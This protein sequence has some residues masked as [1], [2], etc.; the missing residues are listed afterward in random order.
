MKWCFLIRFLL[1]FREGNSIS[2]HKVKRYLIVLDILVDFKPRNHLHSSCYQTG[3]WAGLI[4]T[5]LSRKN[6]SWARVCPA[7]VNKVSPRSCFVSSYRLDSSDHNPRMTVPTSR[8]CCAHYHQRQ[9]HFNFNAH[10][11]LPNAAFEVNEEEAGLTD[12]K[13]SDD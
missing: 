13:D 7:S 5:P 2:Y 8:L 10:E 11:L 6:L 12:V 1:S 3:R 4:F 9:Y